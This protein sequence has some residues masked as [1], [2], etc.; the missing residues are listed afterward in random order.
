MLL[1]AFAALRTHGVA[2][3]YQKISGLFSATGGDGV[4]G[5]LLLTCE[6]WPADVGGVVTMKRHE[7]TTSFECPVR[8]CPRRILDF[9]A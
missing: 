3:R 1:L 7:F 6:S 9:S 5:Y 4:A 2:A 8:V